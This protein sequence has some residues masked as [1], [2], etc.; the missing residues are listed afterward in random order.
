MY[1]FAQLAWHRA[2]STQTWI[3]QAYSD[4]TIKI[5]STQSAGAI[6]QLENSHV[7]LG[8]YR[9]I[10]MMIERSL[11]Y[12]AVIS[13]KVQGIV[14]G[15]IS[16]AG[17]QQGSALNGTAAVS[18]AKAAAARSLEGPTL[19]RGQSFDPEDRA[20]QLEWTHQTEPSSMMAQEAIYTTVLRGL[21]DAA[22][23]DPATIVSE[24]NARSAAIGP[25]LLDYWC[26]FRISTDPD[27][28]YPGPLTY[29]LVTKSF[30]DIAGYIMPQARWYG[31]YDI[32]LYYQQKLN[33]YVEV[34]KSDTE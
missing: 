16:I 30:R 6:Y 21:A 8:L 27:D 23:Y 25:G 13:L 28:G 20:F 10:R 15:Y 14:V 18:P 2:I 24:V 34:T 1:K 3:T 29:Y 4:V 31:E 12:N 9:G 11:W 17:P 5:T 32:D 22:F 19:V 26:N 33:A 7:I